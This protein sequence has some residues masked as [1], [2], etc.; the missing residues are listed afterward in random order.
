MHTSILKLV[1][2]HVYL[3]H[4]LANHLA[5]FR[6][7]KYGEYIYIYIYIERE[8]ERERERVYVL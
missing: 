8:R 6:E 2:I 7:G 3:L 1:Y 5:I 4:V